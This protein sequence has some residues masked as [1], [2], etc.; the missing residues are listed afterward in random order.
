[1]ALWRDEVFAE[2]DYA[3]MHDVDLYDKAK[4]GDA[5]A[6]EEL[7]RRKPRLLSDALELVCGKHP[8]TRVRLIG[9]IGRDHD[10]LWGTTTPGWRV[11]VTQRLNTTSRTAALASLQ[12]PKSGGAQW[13]VEPRWDAR[14]CTPITDGRAWTAACSCGEAVKVSAPSGV[15][16]F[17][18]TPQRTTESESSASRINSSTGVD[19]FRAAALRTHSSVLDASSSNRDGS[20]ECFASSTSDALT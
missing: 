11:E 4:N 19:E 12:D 3:N 8:N 9:A 13:I 20:V 15:D 18:A 5:D 1:M 6:I 2:D 7:R 10:G 16:G 17:S 14:P